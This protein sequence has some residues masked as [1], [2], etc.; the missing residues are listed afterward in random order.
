MAPV[1]LAPAVARRL[2]DSVVG[3]DHFA[4]GS[5]SWDDDQRGF[6]FGDPSGRSWAVRVE[7][8]TSDGVPTVPA[9]VALPDQNEAGGA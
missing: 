1:L 2:A 5:L 8:V 3:S 4:A 6:R 7:P 9:P